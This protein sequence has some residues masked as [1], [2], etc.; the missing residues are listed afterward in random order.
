[1]YV[2]MCVYHAREGE[3]DA[4]VALHEDRQ[5]H[6]YAQGGGWLAGEL[7]HDTQYPRRFVAIAHYESEA[8]ALAAAQDP[9]HVAWQRRLESLC[10]ATP[11]YSEYEAVPLPGGCHEG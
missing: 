9:E 2:T 10:Q 1:M 5:R 11:E 6:L 8:A 3:E 7:L 4:I